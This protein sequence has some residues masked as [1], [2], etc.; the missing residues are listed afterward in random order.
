MTE[1]QK[2]YNSV[3]FNAFIFMQVS[4]LELTCHMHPQQAC[5][6]GPCL[7]WLGTSSN[8]P[9]LRFAVYVLFLCDDVMTEL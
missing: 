7:T 6:A 9:F 4:S 5:A 1:S 2:N 3:V 8:L